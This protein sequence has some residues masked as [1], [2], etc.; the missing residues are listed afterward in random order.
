MSRIVQ[1]VCF[2]RLKIYE[3]LDIIQ[4]IMIGFYILAHI[5]INFDSLGER[6]IL[7]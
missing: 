5:T 7:G 3:H 4:S 6:A 1:L 2:L